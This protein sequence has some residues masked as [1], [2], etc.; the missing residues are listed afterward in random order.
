MK[1]TISF[2]F[3][4]LMSMTV[5]GSGKTP[6][7]SDGYGTPRC[8]AYDAGGTEEH[9]DHFSCDECLRSHPNC[10]M[11]CFSYDYSCQVSGTIDRSERRIDPRTGQETWVRVSQPFS[12]TVRGRTRYEANDRAYYE[13]RMAGAMN[14]N[15]SCSENA[16][17]TQRRSCMR[18]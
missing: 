7:S 14:C 3:S 17:E 18:R 9:G 1:L 13:C 6:P 4:I 8:A 12:S 15:V 10:E 11:K 2:L 5:F 16:Y